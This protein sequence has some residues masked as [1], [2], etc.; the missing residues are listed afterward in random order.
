MA[1]AGQG[2]SKASNSAAQ[3]DPAAIAL[4]EDDLIQS[5]KKG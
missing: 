2:Q 3:Q 5:Q 4:P 1:E